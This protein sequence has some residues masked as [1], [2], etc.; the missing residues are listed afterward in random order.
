MS[1]PTTARRSFHAHLDRIENRALGLLLQRRLAAV[2]ELHHIEHRV[3]DRRRVALAE[4]LMNTH[5]GRQL[6]GEALVGIVAMVARDLVV[7]GQG[8]IEE[9]RL[10]ER[11]LG[12]RLLIV[13]RHHPRIESGGKARLVFGF[14]I[15][16]RTG[17]LRIDQTERDSYRC[18]GKQKKEDDAC[19]LHRGKTPVARWR[20]VM[21]RALSNS[22]YFTRTSGVKQISAGAALRADCA[23]VR[24]RYLRC[25]QPAPGSSAHLGEQIQHVVGVLFF[26]LVDLL[27]QISWWSDRCRP[28]I[29][30]FPRRSGLRSARRPGL[31]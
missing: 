11:D 23:R 7:R 19:G 8:V 3:E 10:A 28:A 5:R 4:L 13:G 15:G 17:S 9:Q 29:E 30:R 16:Q 18:C 25:S 1:S 22:N 27:D 6:I 26:H 20:S 12:R 2:P 24:R 31:P 21:L 14:G